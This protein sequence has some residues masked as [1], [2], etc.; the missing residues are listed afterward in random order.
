[1]PDREDAILRH[2]PTLL[3][4][5]HGSI[6]RMSGPTTSHRSLTLRLEQ[7]GRRGNLEIACIYPTHIHAPVEWHESRI[8][9][10]RD[11]TGFAVVD[12]EHE[13]RILCSHVEIAEN[14]KPLNAFTEPNTDGE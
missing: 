10:I 8:D 6:V 13:V 4:R 12:E 5:W 2:F 14:R 9:V 1:M 11:G 7:H 3:S